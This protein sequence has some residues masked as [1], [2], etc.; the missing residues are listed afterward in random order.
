MPKILLYTCA[1]L[2]ILVNGLF[3]LFAY[4][5]NQNHNRKMKRIREEAERRK[6]RER[7]LT[8]YDLRDETYFYVDCFGSLREECT[9][10]L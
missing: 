5:K 1:A 9:H 7:T 8:E 4:K 3:A 2:Y 10:P 6:E